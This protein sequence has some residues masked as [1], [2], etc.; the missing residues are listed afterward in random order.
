MLF[1]TCIFKLGFLHLNS[2]YFDRVLLM[3][4]CF[5]LCCYDTDF[6]TY[7]VNEYSYSHL[8]LLRNSLFFYQVYFSAVD[9]IDFKKM[10][11]WKSMFILFF[12]CP[13]SHYFEWVLSTNYYFH[14][15]CY[16]P[17]GRP[18]NLPQSA[19]RLAELFFW[20]DLSWLQAD[21]CSNSYVIS[22]RVCLLSMM[23]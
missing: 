6:K 8:V 7:A 9:R 1:W 4:Y 10:L 5:H 16:G 3:N 11:F 22:T 20:S 17:K 21:L 12:W 14:L 2:C 19:W 23:P 13:Y 18:N 15:C